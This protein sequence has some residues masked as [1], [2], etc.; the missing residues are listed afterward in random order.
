MSTFWQETTVPDGIYKGTQS[1][2][3]VE[4]LVND[5]RVKFHSGRGLRGINIPVTVTIKDG[6]ATVNIAKE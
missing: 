3:E 4:I 5:K 2:Y 1:G 6:R